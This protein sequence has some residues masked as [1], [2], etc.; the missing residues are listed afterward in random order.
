MAREVAPQQVLEVGLV[1]QVGLGVAVRAG[2]DRTRERREGAQPGVEQ[3]QPGGGP[4]DRG[5]LL[6][7]TEA[8]QD[9]HRLT[10][11]VHRTRVGEGLGVPVDD[12]D[13]DAVLREQ[14]RDGEPRRA[15][16]DDEHG[17]GH[18][19]AAAVHPLSLTEAPRRRAPNRAAAQVAACAAT[20]VGARQPV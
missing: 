4:A 11:E 17:D 19:H 2:R 6:V 9:A 5:E 18:G 7:H 10:V 3:A 1:E 12:H 15:G 14:R 16:A 8:L 20:T 13:R